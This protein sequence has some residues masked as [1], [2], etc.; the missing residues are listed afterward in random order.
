MITLWNWP[1]TLSGSLLISIVSSL[2]ISRHLVSGFPLTLTRTGLYLFLFVTGIILSLKLDFFIKKIRCFSPKSVLIFWFFTIF[3]F[4]F[5]PESTTNIYSLKAELL[6]LTSSVACS[7]II[8]LCIVEG[9]AKKLL[10]GNT[11]QKLGEISYS[12]YLTHFVTMGSILHGLNGIVPFK[13][14]LFISIFL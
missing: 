2:L 10:I 1:I 13:I 9:K 12:L 5:S 3:I 6:M 14:S 11:M 4:L 8:I 7:S